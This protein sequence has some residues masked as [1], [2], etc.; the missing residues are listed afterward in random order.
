MCLSLRFVLPS[1][2]VLHCYIK[3]ATAQLDRSFQCRSLSAACPPVAVDEPRVL[4]SVH[5]RLL[6]QPALCSEHGLKFE[7]FGS[8][9]MKWRAMGKRLDSY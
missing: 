4:L 3:A 7:L 2:F 1:L 8:A 9:E 6:Q 5:M